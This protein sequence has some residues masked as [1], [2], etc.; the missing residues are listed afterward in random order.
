MSQGWVYVVILAN[1][2]TLPAFGRATVQGSSAVNTGL[3]AST[4]RY[5]V[6]P[7][8]QTALPSSVTMSGNTLNSVAYWA[9]LS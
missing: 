3:T 1:A 4:A 8:G 7:S 9:A 6:S 5:A 2:A